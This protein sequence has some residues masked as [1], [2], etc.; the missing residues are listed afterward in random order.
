MLLAGAPGGQASDS[1]S[2]VTANGGNQTGVAGLRRREK[3]ALPKALQAHPVTSVRHPVQRMSS[4]A[5][6]PSATIA[7]TLGNSVAPLLRSTDGGVIE[8]WLATR[9]EGSEHT[10]RAYRRE[11]VRF[12]LWL[13][14][15][16]GR[17]LREA[18]LRDCLDFREFLADPPPQWCGLRGPVIGSDDW[19]PLQG[20]LSIGARRQAVVIL[21]NLYR[22]LQDQALVEGN[23]WSAVRTPK[24]AAPRIDVGRSLTKAQWAAVKEATRCQ[25]LCGSEHDA[26]QLR[27]VVD[28]LYM[29]GLRRAEMVT[30]TVGDLRWVDIDEPGMSD[31][32]SE[33]RLGGWVIDVVG[34]G[35]RQRQVPVPCDLVQDLRDLLSLRSWHGG[36]EAN[37]YRP[38]LV[39]WAAV[40]SD[41]AKTPTK[42][43]PAMSER[44][45][46]RK[47]KQ[48]F[49]VAATEM[50]RRGRPQDACALERASVHSLR[51]TFGVHAV[52]ADVP[53]DVIQ[54][55]L[56][57]ASLATTTVYVRAQLGRRL[58]ESR[59]LGVDAAQSALHPSLSEHVV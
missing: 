30:A 38:L 21:T 26:L 7:D 42:P 10:A 41:D 5:F 35:Q 46:A 48:V 2:H 6:A 16:R 31:A 44:G 11:A 17:A 25:R 20:P 14:V 39:A 51:H 36:L 23:P 56:G 9:A 45:L 22:F 53:L 4:L 13:N 32:R 52:E 29:T 43:L 18:T 1:I 37:L 24:H 12:L 50:T 28:F 49:L 40:K 54:Q 55:T 19:R 27:W 59:R 47:L 8:L 3:R 33:P 58:K 57:H 15:E 34:K